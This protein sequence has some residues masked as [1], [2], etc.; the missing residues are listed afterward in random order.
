MANEIHQYTIP[1]EIILNQIHYLRGQKIMLDTDLAELYEVETKQLKRQVRRNIE[2]FPEDF[3][4][5]LT[6]IEYSSLRSQ[7]DTLKRG[8]HSKYLPMAFTE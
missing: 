3:M 4:F 8:E 1:D 5:E 2:R 7:I 6:D